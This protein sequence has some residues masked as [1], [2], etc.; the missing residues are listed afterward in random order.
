MWP[1]LYY[2]CEINTGIH[3]YTFISACGC[4][5]RFEQKFWWVEKFSEQ[6]ARVGGFAYPYSPPSE[7]EFDLICSTKSRLTLFNFFLLKKKRLATFQCRYL[8]WL[9]LIS[10][11]QFF[12][13][14]ILLL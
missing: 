10:L 5:F 2:L 3:T 11:A 8:L 7:I 13:L 12:S 6:K 4:G 9:A 14:S 1:S